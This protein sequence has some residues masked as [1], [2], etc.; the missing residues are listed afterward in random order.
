[1]TGDLAA[2]KVAVGAAATRRPFQVS[3]LAHHGTQVTPAHLDMF[4][5]LSP[6]LIRHRVAKMWHECGT[7]F[8]DV[9]VFDA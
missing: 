3:Y 4:R 2:R 7:C 8:K 1:M 5:N 6:R 9:S